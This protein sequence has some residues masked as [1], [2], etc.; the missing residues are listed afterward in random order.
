[1]ELMKRLSEYNAVSGD[2]MYLMAELFPEPLK[3][4]RPDNMPLIDALGN[5]TLFKSGRRHDKT[6]AFIAHTDE[7]GFIVRDITDKGYIK[8]ETV[9]SID[10]RVMISKKVSIGKDKISGILGMKAI[11]LQKKE[12][13]ESVV[14]VKELYIDIGAK[15]KA[16]AQRR[17]S[18]GDRISFDTQFGALSEDVIKGKALDRMGV[19]CLLKVLEAE[20]EYDTYY[21]FTAQRHIEGRGAAVAFERICP[22]AVY[23]ID[24]IETS[25][26]YGAKPQEK[27]AALGDGAIIGAMDKGGIYDRALTERLKNTGARV[28]IMNTVPPATEIGAVRSAFYGTAAALIGIPCRYA[29]T[30]VSLMNIQDIEAV[31]KVLRSLI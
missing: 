26:T 12:E 22:D 19:Y 3:K 6:V 10:P 11:H 27:A 16:D 13:R 25:E 9:G 30:P 31:C 1:M 17:V 18:L 20:P 23:V 29:N 2:E 24:A 21:I 7:A 14:P 15:D 4:Y 5:V 8:F 28:Q